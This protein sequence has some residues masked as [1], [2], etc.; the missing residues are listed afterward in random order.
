MSTFFLQV[1]FNVKDDITSST[2]FRIIPA[3]ISSKSDYNDFAPM[4]FTEQRLIDNVVNCL[5]SNGKSME[6][7]VQAYPLE[8]E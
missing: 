1:K 7:A 3:R 4:P 8:W 5:L 6:Y 2:G